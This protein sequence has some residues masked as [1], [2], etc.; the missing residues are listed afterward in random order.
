MTVA[1]SARFDRQSAGMIFYWESRLLLSPKIEARGV[2]LPVLQICPLFDVMIRTVDDERDLLHVTGVRLDVGPVFE[3]ED[4][5][6]RIHAADQNHARLIMRSAIMRRHE[7]APVHMK[8]RE[9]FVRCPFIEPMREHR[10]IGNHFEAGACLEFLAAFVD[11]SI[12]RADER[13]HFVVG[14]AGS[15]FGHFLGRKQRALADAQAKRGRSSPLTDIA[16]PEPA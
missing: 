9:H 14:R 10:V 4:E 3:L 5:A 8:H 13:F 12:P 7:I 11:G 1:L 2:F 16:A 6:I 15:D